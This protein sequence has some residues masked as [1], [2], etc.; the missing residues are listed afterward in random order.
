MKAIH[1]VAALLLST[2]V[3]TVRAE[4]EMKAF[5]PADPGMVRFVLHLPKEDDETTLKLELIVGKTVKTDGVNR[6]FFGGKI[7]EQTI[8][9]WGF[10][11]YFVSKLGPMAGTLM[12]VDPDKPQVARFVS[13]GREPFIIRYNSRIPVVLYLPEGV[14]ARHR[15]WRADQKTNEMEKG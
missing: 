6:H 1:W 13:L 12:A 2:V 7:E 5:P 10:T 8:E 14:E 15:I 11:R 9:G 3:T 4:N